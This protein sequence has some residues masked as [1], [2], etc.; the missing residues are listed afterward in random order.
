[1]RRLRKKEK[2]H[3]LE[4]I[5]NLSA[6]G[7]AYVWICST[8]MSCVVGYKVWNRRCFK[9]LLS[10]FSTDSDES[11][12]VLV[13]EN[14]YQRWMEEARHTTGTVVVQTKEDNEDGEDND[15]NDEEPT[16][17]HNEH[18][19]EN[20]PPAK[21]TNS[22]G[23][24]SSGK[25]SNRRCSGWS[26]EGFKRF[27]TLYALVKED[28][29]RRANFELDLKEQCQGQRNKTDKNDSAESDGEE[30]IPAND[31]AGAKQPPAFAF[32]E[33]DD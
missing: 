21:Y 14:N 9:E 32:E 13:V 3:E 4:D 29:K 26:K 23:S 27:N 7:E 6:G 33:E 22:V 19:K 31:M 25:G 10:D 11:F 20:L 1:M 18:W 30:I 28:C 24:S 16:E 2:C 5:L 8:L 12:L 17:E 15:D